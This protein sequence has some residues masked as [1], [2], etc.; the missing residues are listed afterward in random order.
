MEKKRCIHHSQKKH[1]PAQLTIDGLPALQGN[2]CPGEILK[3]F[4]LM[5][6][7]LHSKSSMVNA[8][9]VVEQW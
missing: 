9:Y 6:E 8:T 2:R 4:P 3:G 1:E 5:G 7:Y